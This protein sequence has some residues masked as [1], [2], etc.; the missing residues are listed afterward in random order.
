MGL[1]SSY[2][3]SSPAASDVHSLF[4]SL[5]DHGGFRFADSR[6]L[7]PGLVAPPK[8]RFGAFG[9]HTELENQDDSSGDDAVM[10]LLAHAIAE[11]LVSADGGSLTDSRLATSRRARVACGLRSSLSKL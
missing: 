6:E 9:F 10:N 11:E 2:H 1:L 5:A 3:D 7:A 8:Q 4:T